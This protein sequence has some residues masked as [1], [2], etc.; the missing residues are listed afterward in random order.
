MILFQTVVLTVL[1][2]FNKNDIETVR[3][4]RRS[5]D[6]TS[7]LEACCATCTGLKL[8]YTGISFFKKAGCRLA[9]YLYEPSSF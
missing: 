9:V 3:K 6:N 1:F 2:D 7:R 5:Y 8:N 4:L